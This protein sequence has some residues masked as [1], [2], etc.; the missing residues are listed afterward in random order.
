MKR[1]SLMLEAATAGRQL[2]YVRAAGA[3]RSRARSGSV[4]A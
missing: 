2:A 1:G 4:R 3:V